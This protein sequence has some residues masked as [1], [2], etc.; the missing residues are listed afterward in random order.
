MTLHSPGPR[1]YCQDDET[2]NVPF[3]FILCIVHSGATLHL[4]RHRIKN[5]KLRADIRMVSV[6]SSS[7]GFFFSIPQNTRGWRADVEEVQ[8][9]QT[10]GLSPIFK[11]KAQNVTQRQWQAALIREII[12]IQHTR[13]AWF[14]KNK[15]KS[16][17]FD[18]FPACM[19]YFPRSSHLRYMKRCIVMTW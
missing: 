13:S 9:D 17:V 5:H 4:Q 14:E 11:S 12:K 1:C 8:V 10:E 15:Q 6:T 3:T 19:P 18:C 16:S 7:W 2:G